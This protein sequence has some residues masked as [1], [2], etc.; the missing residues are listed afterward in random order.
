MA[1][2]LK[3]AMQLNKLLKERKTVIK[4]ISSELAGQIGLQKALCDSMK[5]DSNLEELEGTVNKT[6]KAMLDASKGAQQFGNKMKKATKDSADGMED[7]E[8]A[9]GNTS[10]A[11][12]AAFGAVSGAVT[13]IAGAIGK[14]VGLYGSFM[15]QAIAVADEMLVGARAAE[16][17]RDKFGDLSS[18]VGGEVRQRVRDFGDAFA[19]AGVSMGFGFAAGAKLMDVVGGMYKEMDPSHM[20]TFLQFTGEAQVQMGVLGMAM[21]LTGKETAA[22]AQRFK[23]LGQDAPME[24]AKIKG[25]AAKL[26]KAIGIDAKAIG[27]SFAEMQGNVKNFGDMST[28]AMGEAIAKAGQLGLGVKE[29]A[30]VSEAFFNFDKAADNV[31]K[32]SQAF[33]TNID[34][35]KMLNAENPA[36]QMDMLRDAMFAAGKSSENMSRHEKALLGSTLGLSAAQA[37]LMFSQEAQYMSQEELDK[38]MADSDPQQQMVNAM[39]DV[40]KEIKSVVHSLNDMGIRAQGFFGAF[41]KGISDGLFKFGPFMDIASRT[42]G[43][44]RELYG[45][46]RKFADLLTGGYMSDGDQ[47]LTPVAQ[48]FQ[49]VHDTLDKIVPAFEWL[50]G[51]DGPLLKVVSAFTAFFKETD[52]EKSAA[53]F[54]DMV[55]N[56]KAAFDG[57]I[58]RVFGEGGGEEM[59]VAFKTMMDKAIPMLTGLMAE[60][61]P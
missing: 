28:E 1:E 40:G 14:V 58:T 27:K 52:P 32:L 61:I 47:A 53:L 23:S 30:S 2:N 59:K 60:A 19:E 5:C 33:G 29:L 41:T 7:V 10:R 38:A 17:L 8:E 20:G 46:G 39:K 37:E 3:T 36:E 22:M 31:S 55:K 34:T 43:I 35:M 15:K 57:M 18:G 24:M 45:I 13:G 16:E 21:G 50:A 42:G 54:D 51:P 26:E 44:L 56:I 9:S 48:A 12:K 11:V 4:Q 49:G 25:M 6:K